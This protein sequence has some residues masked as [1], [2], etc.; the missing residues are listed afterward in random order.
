[1]LPQAAPALTTQEKD[2]LME[3]ADMLD[4][5][6]YQSANA[7]AEVQATAGTGATA[8]VNGNDAVG[9]INI[10]TG[11]NPAPGPLVHVKFISPYK[12]QPFV[13]IAPMDQ[14]PP[15]GWY[16]TVDTNGFDIWVSA[17]PKAHTNYPFSYF[18]APRPWLMY[19]GAQQATP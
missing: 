5:R 14:P 8:S 4:S 13:I 9:Q 1:V 11:A 3:M 17:A 19:L 6:L 12:T 10:Q 7:V 16:T 15:D 2:T 18:V